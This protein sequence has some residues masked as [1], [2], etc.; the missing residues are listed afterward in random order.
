MQYI[1]PFTYFVRKPKTGWKNVG[2]GCIC[3]FVPIAGQ[4]V[5]FG[6]RAEVSDDLE[7][8]P[9][10]ERYGDFNA[11]RL[12]PYF[13]RGVWP[14]LANLIVALSVIV[15]AYIL[16]IVAGVLI[17]QSTGE[18]LL[19]AAAYV[20]IFAV[21]IIGMNLLV[22]P[23]ELHAMKTRK[24][25]LIAE[26]K[27]AMRFLRVVGLETVV[28]IFLFNMLGQ[29]LLLAGLLLCIVGI[30]PA[31]VIYTMAEQH[32]MLQLY[33]RYIEEG[34]EP[35]DTWSEFEDDK[36]DQPRPKARRVE[37]EIE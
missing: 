14:F 35:I 37:A 21:A 15:P 16:S 32:V 3:S 9:A 10:L 6:Y 20:G 22:W 18:I 19:A 31:A 12:M 17:L 24:L 13:Q 30:Y 25:H 29:V 27:F 34:G 2:I 36:D 23:M 4:I 33:Q 8:D 5:W 26:L 11:D 1:K 28:S 7:R